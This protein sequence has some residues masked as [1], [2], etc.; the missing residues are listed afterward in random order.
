M[1][2]CSTCSGS[3]SRAPYLSGEGCRRLARLAAVCAVAL[4]VGGCGDSTGP[5][6]PP[7][8]VVAVSPELR[9]LV[10]GDT[11]SLSVAVLDGSGVE[12]DEPVTW[13]SSDNT[14]AT[15]DT[16][17]RV[18]AIGPG[19]AIIEARVHQK[20]DSAIIDVDLVR[21]VALEAGVNDVCGLTSEGRIY[22]WGYGGYP[23]RVPG[24]LTFTS[25]SVSGDH[26]CAVASDE[27]AYCWT[28][29]AETPAIV[30]GDLRFAQVDVGS[31]H[32]C[33]VT[34][35]GGAYCWGG[36]VHGQLGDG[37]T[38][39]SETPVS[40]AGGLAFAGVSAGWRHTCGVT[41]DGEAYCWGDNNHAK[42]G[43]G[44]ASGLGIPTPQPVIGEL[45]FRQL[46]ASHHHFVCGIT[47]ADELYCW[48]HNDYG[49][50]GRGFTSGAEV[51]PEPVSGGGSWRL[52]HGQFLHVCGLTLAGSAFC[53]GRGT[54]GQLGDGRAETS[55]VPVAVAGNLAFEL[56]SAGG[57]SSC[58]IAS[59]GFAYCWGWSMLGLG[60]DEVH[61]TPVRVAGQPL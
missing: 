1:R 15:V 59:D 20:S 32:A 2:S 41:V 19:S 61:L 33:G 24:E 40:V 4:V 7:G 57:S 29:N 23:R 54:T 58:A 36:N 43:L 51:T 6:L 50:L 56:V 30:P 16:A 18:T 11:F 52:V 25:L 13:K 26:H 21:Y 44:Y 45:R 34:S 55:F 5:S 47:V 22:C 9:G 28:D 46:H 17:G 60:S 27:H 48:G 14:V 31:D 38:E 10:P 49:M 42:L 37:T 53:W 8:S 3:A 35:N 12:L 39:P